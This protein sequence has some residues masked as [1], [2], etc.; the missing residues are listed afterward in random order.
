[1][2]SL[3]NDSNISTTSSCDLSWNLAKAL[4]LPHVQ[5]RSLNS[6]AYSVQFKMKIFAGTAFLVDE[7]VPKVEKRFTGTEQ[8]RRC[9]L[10]MANCHTE[11]EKD[12]PQNQLN[13]ANHVVSVFAGNIQC[14]FAMVAYNE[15]LFYISYSLCLTF[16][17]C[18][19]MI[20]FYTSLEVIKLAF[21]ENKSRYVCCIFANF[22]FTFETKS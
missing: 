8:R 1:M 22:I 5:Q 11:T 13:S 16:C 2:W 4:A 12:M 15:I 14:K 19:S 10:H 9:Q 3:I 18:S 6:L 17:L 7:P 21:L 20:A